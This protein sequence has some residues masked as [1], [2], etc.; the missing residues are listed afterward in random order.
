LFIQIVIVLAAAIVCACS[1]TGAGGEPGEPA[2]GGSGAAPTETQWPAPKF[3]ISV[4]KGERYLVDADGRPFLIQGDAAWSLIAELS[5]EDVERYLR[6][7]RARGFN[8][9]LVNLIEH[10]F[11]RHPPLN[12]Y[13]DAPFA[14]PGD[15]GT[16]NDRYFDHA[17]WVLARAEQ[18]GLL[19][20]LTPMYMGN[21]G[22]D[23][24]WYQEIRRSGADKIR[25]FG[26]YIGR[27][28][29][30]HRNVLWIQGGDYNPPDKNLVRALVQGI[31]ES[32]PAAL[33]S[34]HCGPETEALDYWNGEP[35]LDLD[36]IYTYE[37]VYLAAMRAYRRPE[38]LPYILIESHYENEYR[39]TPLQLRTQAFH[40]L[41]S[42]ATG[43]I[44][45]NSPIW[46]FDGP[47]LFAGPADWRTELGSRGAHSMTNI[48]RLFD[49]IAW[50]KLRPDLDQHL[51]VGGIG[52]GKRR[53]VA[54][55][56][57]DD[58]FAVVYVPSDRAVA[59]DLGQLSGPRVRG[60][61]Y[62]PGL[63]IF[64]P[65]SRTPFPATGIRT[66]NERRSAV[67]SFDKILVLE[68]VE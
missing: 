13:G 28:F 35:W 40:A 38:G 18:M 24:G 12:A 68:S 43:Q 27:R 30:A 31:R 63:G 53:A 4:V 29:K 20:M 1:D 39:S 58:S 45:G 62:D 49:G 67:G 59:I 42:G 34:A 7:R 17:D 52:Q 3:P 48:R 8:A 55:L 16:P 26:R 15:F 56:A 2:G 66:L 64:A 21:G 22:G 25:D 33:Q 50:W 5:R 10:K 41:L 32:D 19:V 9:V 61:W 54:A 44:F 11:A 46:H 51:L 6:D 36:T 23:E 47:G 65:A 14:I 60:R 57:S 37:P